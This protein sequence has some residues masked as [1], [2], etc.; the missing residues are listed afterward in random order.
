MHSE[1]I[2]IQSQS[3]T[4]QS[5]QVS[6][7]S[8]HISEINPLINQI[9]SVPIQQNSQQPI[10][11]QQGNVQCINASTQQVE[12]IASEQSEIRTSHVQ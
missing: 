12:L 4:T 1:Y 5:W 11:Y 6:V 10:H 7:H 3:K 9:W 2:P 8:Q